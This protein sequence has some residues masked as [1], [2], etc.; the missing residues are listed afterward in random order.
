MRASQETA[1]SEA[2][3]TLAALQELRAETSE[4]LAGR[5][6]RT[7]IATRAVLAEQA[8]R[9]A[10]QARDLAS[11]A[12]ILAEAL[13]TG[14]TPRPIPFA[15]ARGEMPLPVTGGA[16]VAGFGA[17]DPWG[18]DGSGLSVRAPAYAQIFAPW[19]GTVRFAG[20]LVGYGKVI[21]LEP[22]EGYLLLLA[23]LKRVDRTV[24]EAILAGERLGDLGG[25]VPSSEE[26]FLEGAQ[27][28][29]QIA[30]ET[31]YIELRHKGVAIDPSPWFE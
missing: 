18:H 7:A 1:R 24:G 3:A 8:D 21:V 19:D 10:A 4:A 11:L 28:G 29:A 15:P 6:P 22:E 5:A 20:D 12:A 27:D 30:Q 14:A 31:F 23:G 2:R 25:P 17:P 26:F 16:V 13:A 9:A